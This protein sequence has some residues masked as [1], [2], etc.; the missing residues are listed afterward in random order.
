MRGY[1]GIGIYHPKHEV[2][3]GTL[4]RSAMIYEADFLFTIGRRYKHQSSDT[5]GATRHVPLWHF[6]SY[7]Q[8]RDNMPLASL[9]CVEITDDSH[10]LG[11]YAHP[12]RAIYMLGAE[13]N[14]IP[15]RILSKCEAV[16]TIPSPR[17]LCLNVAT[18]GTIVLYDRYTK[19]T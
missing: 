8:F 19:G 7:D 1:C 17:P 18:A 5:I 2:N 4:W 14:G 11:H 13:D 15:G 12:Q 3:I 16:V 9:I 6:A 10:G